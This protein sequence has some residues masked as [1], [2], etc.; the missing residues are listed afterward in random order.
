MLR[1]RYRMYFVL[2]IKIFNTRVLA[3]LT[4]TITHKT[5]GADL[6]SDH[7]CSGRRGPCHMVLR[8][9]GWK[10]T[11]KF[12]L[13]LPKQDFYSFKLY[14]AVRPVDN[15]NEMLFPSQKFN[16]LNVCV[17]AKTKNAPT[18]QRWQKKRIPALVTRQRWPP[19]PEMPRV[20]EVGRWNQHR[21][22]GPLGQWPTRTAENSVLY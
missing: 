20:S 19:P 17:A 4:T 1:L 12:A 18:Q 6:R 22:G 16:S 2:W 14:D 9:P 8:C 11:K 10:S 7:M 15:N 5:T 21:S 3:L 13:Q